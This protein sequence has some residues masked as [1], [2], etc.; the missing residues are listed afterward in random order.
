MG[1]PAASENMDTH[2]HLAQMFKR[3]IGVC[4]PKF[5]HQS[6]ATEQECFIVNEMEKFIRHEKATSDNMEDDTVVP[7]PSRGIIVLV[8]HKERAKE[9]DRLFK[10]SKELNSSLLATESNSDKKQNTLS[11]NIEAQ[12]DTCNVVVANADIIQE[13]LHSGAFWWN[14]VSALI[15]IDAQQA[16]SKSC[17]FSLIV[18]ESYR[19]FCNSQRPPILSIVTCDP[20]ETC[21]G[22]IE[23]NLL[24]EFPLPTNSLEWRSRPKDLVEQYNPRNLFVDVFEYRSDLR[25]K[26]KIKHDYIHHVSDIQLL[27]RELGPYGVVLY[28]RCLRL[29]KLSLKRHQKYPQLDMSSLFVNGSKRPTIENVDYPV[30]ISHKALTLLDILHRASKAATGADKLKAQIFAGTPEVA[31]ALNQMIRSISSLRGLQSRVVIGDEE[32]AKSVEGISET[33]FNWHSTEEDLLALDDYGIGDVNILVIAS[34]NIFRIQRNLRPLPPCG[35]I[36]RFDGSYSNPRKDGGGG[37]CRVV[38]F[39]KKREDERMFSGPSRKRG[40]NSNGTHAANIKTEGDT[41]EAQPTDGSGKGK[42]DLGFSKPK[43]MEPRKKNKTCRGY[44]TCPE[45]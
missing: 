44:C 23:T 29:R 28:Q 11:S 42:V 13:F 6:Q 8:K 25:T 2:N 4:V 12:F 36:I 24:V 15:I 45:K 9:V 33:H 38:V 18:R 16:D 22:A 40:R 14:R 37:P 17:I 35:F 7:R 39:H 3:N 19:S 26:T 30:G 32:A 34:T 21:L 43:I 5:A 27:L 41:H 1:M 31:V 20:E 10:M